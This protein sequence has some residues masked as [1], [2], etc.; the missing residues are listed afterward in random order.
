MPAPKYS[1]TSLLEVFHQFADD[2]GINTVSRSKVA[3]AL[4]QL[5]S[6]NNNVENWQKNTLDAYLRQ[7][8]VPA[9]PKH[10]LALFFEQIPKLL[11]RLQLQEFVL[12]LKESN[13]SISTI[14][15]YRSDIGQFLDFAQDSDLATLL[16]KPKINSFVRYQKQKGLKQSSITR[17]LKSIAQFG[18]WARE[19]GIDETQRDWLHNLSIETVAAP[20][21]VVP[22]ARNNSSKIHSNTKETVTA[23][24]A[25]SMAEWSDKI[26]RQ[27]AWKTRNQILPYLNLALIIL[28]FLGVTIF[29]YQQLTSESTP[30]L[31]YPTAV[32]R[33]TRV[34]SFQ[35]RLTDTAQNPITSST[36]MRF[37]LYD[38]VTGG[39]QL[40][41][42]GTCS[43]SPDQDGIFATGLGD[44]CGSEISADVFSENDSIWLEVEVASETLTPRQPIRT[45]PYAL[46]SETVQGFPINATESATANTILV[47][48]E[49][50]EVV[51]GENSPTI[52]STSGTFTLEGEAV[53]IQT[54][55]GSNGDIT[56]SPDGTGGVIITSTTTFQDSITVQGDGILTGYLAAPGATLSATYAG[57]TALVVQG[58][59]SGTATIQEWQQ[60]DGTVLNVIDENGYLGI[61]DTDPDALVNIQGTTEQLRLDYDDSNYVSFTVA[62]DGGL[63]IAGTGT[64]ADISLNP[65]GDLLFTDLDC[66]S[67][68]NGGALTV[69]AGGVVSCS[70]D[71]SGAGSGTSYWR[72]TSGA[73]S[74][75]ND[76][77][78]LL[79][80]GVSTASAKFAFINANSGTPTASISGNLA[81]AAP[82][83]ADPAITFDALNG[84]SLNF[85]T[86]VGG[87]AGSTTRVIIDNDGNVIPGAD[88]TYNLGSDTARWANLYVGTGGASFG[89]SGDAGTIDFNTTTDAFDL[90]FGG[91]QLSI[92]DVSNRP[93]FSSS[94]ATAIDFL[95]DVRISADNLDL[96]IGGS[97]DLQLTHNG[98]DSL[99]TSYTNDL[100]L[101]ADDDST[102]SQIQFGLEDGST[103]LG[104]FITGTNNQ[105]DFSV[106]SNTL[107]VDASSDSVGI[108]DSS[109]AS[110]FTVGNGDLFQ[111][112]NTGSII[113]I[114]GVAHSIA[115]VG[116]DLELN[117]NGGQI[118]FTD[119]DV[120]NIGGVTNQGY[121]A[122]SDAGT[123]TYASSDNDL[124]VE[125]I[126]EVDGTL[127]VGD[128]Q[129]SANALWQNDANV[130]HAANQYAGV[131]DLVVGG[132]STASA[133]IHL[134]ATNG[135][136]SA[137]RFQDLANSAYYLDPAA[138]GYSLLTAGS[139]G[140]G[141]TTP[142]AFLNIQGTTE[143]L[144]LDYDDSNYLS[145]TVASDGGT[146]F[147]GTGT[148]ADIIFDP[149][150]DL[151]FADL[152]CTGNTNGGS[153]TVDASGIVSCSDDDSGSS[154]TNY[155]RLTDGALS[156][157]NDTYDLLIG[158]ESTTSAAF[159]FMNV[160]S[161]TP[162]ASISGN[163]ALAAPTGSNPTTSLDILNGG[164]FNLRTSV[165][166][167]AGLTSRL[168]IDNDGNVGIGTETPS[169]Q[170]DIA[171][172][173]STIS[174]SS[175]DITLNAASDQI[176][177]S[178]D[179][180]GNLLNI[181]ASGQ[182]KPGSYGAN[183]TA[184]GNGAIIYRSDQTQLYYYDGTT[185]QSIASDA[186]VLFEN[187]A[188]VIHPKDELAEIADFVIGGTSTSSANIH[189][190]ATN[191]Y[192][193]GQRFQ[194]RAN[195]AYYLD[196][197][198]TDTSLTL[199]GKTGLGVAAP[200]FQ[201]E[202]EAANAG[203]T[204]AV[205]NQL[206]DQSIFV[207][208]SSGTNVFEL[209]NN[210]DV[211]IGNPTIDDVNIELHG[212]L[213]QPDETKLETA[214]TDIRQTFLYDT[215]QDRDGGAWRKSIISK[216]LSWYTESKDDAGLIAG[217]DLASDDRCGTSYFPAK[218]NL[219]LTNNALYVMDVTSNKLWMKFDQ[220]TS[221]AL[222]TT[223][224]NEPQS[225]YAKNGRLFVGT[226]GSSSETGLY[227]INFRTDE[228]RYYDTTGRTT[229]DENISGRNNGSHAFSGTEDAYKLAN[230]NINDIDGGYADGKQYL[231]VA[232]DAGVN[233]VDLDY[234]LTYDYKE[235]ASNANGDTISDDG[236]ASADAVNAFDGI[237]TTYVRSDAADDTLVVTYQFG[238]AK[239]I[240]R[241]GLVND[242]LGTFNEFPATWTF[243]GS[244]NGSTWTTLDTQTDYLF[245]DT[246]LTSNYQYFPINNDTAYTYYR[247]NVTDAQN[248]SADNITIGEI[249]LQERH[250]REAVRLFSDDVI[251][252]FNPAASAGNSAT[253]YSH[254]RIND[255]RRTNANG[256]FLTTSGV[257]YPEL[258]LTLREPDIFAKYMVTP[259]SNNTY[260]PTDWDLKASNDGVN[261]TT[262]DSE[263][264]VV[265]STYQPQTFDIASYSTAYK[266]YRLD[267]TGNNGSTLNTEVADFMMGT[268]T[269]TASTSFNDTTFDETN[270]IFQE[271]HG[272][273]YYWIASGDVDEW[274]QYDYG[275]GGERTMQA[276]VVRGYQTSQPTRA[277]TDWRV[278]GSNNGSTWTT[279][280]TQTS[281][282]WS[283]DNELKTYAFSNSTAYRY[284]RIYV[285]AVNGGTLSSFKQFYMLGSE[286]RLVASSDESDAAD[287]VSR[288]KDYGDFGR[289]TSYAGD[290]SGWIVKAFAPD[291][292]ATVSGIVLNGSASLNESIKDFT[293]QGSNDFSTWTDLG[294]IDR[295]VVED[296]THTRS[297]MFPND[298]A[299]QFYRLNIEAT[300]NS[301]I[302]SLDELDLLGSKYNNVRFTGDGFVATNV[303]TGQLDVFNKIFDNE[304]TRTEDGAEPNRHKALE[305]DGGGGLNT[306]KDV[307]LTTSD[308]DFEVDT[309]RRM[310]PLLGGGVEA[311]RRA[312]EVDG[313]EVF[314]GHANG[315]DQIRIN[316]NLKLEGTDLATDDDGEGRAQMQARYS[317]S[318]TIANKYGFEHYW[319][320]EQNDDVSKVYNFGIANSHSEVFGSGDYDNIPTSTASGK[321]GR[322]LEFDEATNQAVMFA[323]EAVQGWGNTS[324]TDEFS[325]G[326]WVRPDSDDVDTL[327]YD[328]LGD[329][330]LSTN[331]YG[332]M[333]RLDGN[334]QRIWL[335]GG[336]GGSGS[337]TVNQYSE[338]AVAE[339]DK[340]THFVIS[341]VNDNQGYVFNYYKN[342]ELVDTQAAGNLIDGGDFYLGAGGASSTTTT[343]DG[344]LDE[345]FI[346]YNALTDDEI[347]SIYN[348]G[349]TYDVNDSASMEG[350]NAITIDNASV[351][352]STTIGDSQLQMGVNE[353]AGRV[354]EITG[355]TGSGQSRLIVKNSATTVT[356]SPAW[357]TTPDSTSDFVITP[358]AVPGSVDEVKAARVDQKD[359]FLG[360]NDGSDGGGVVR[361]NRS[362]YDVTDYYHSGA[363]KTDDDSTAWDTTSGYD[364]I[365][366]IETTQDNL[367]IAS[368]TSYWRE[369][370]GDS[371]TE[372]IDKL[373]QA[374]SASIT[375][376]YT[377]DA[378]G[379]STRD[380]TRQVLRKGWSFLDTDDAS[381]DVYYG[382]SY[383][384]IP[385]VYISPAGKT[386]LSEIY[387]EP[388]SLQ[389]CQAAGAS[390]NEIT[391]GDIQRNQF[392]VQEETG[393]NSCFT[394][395]SIGD[396][397]GSMP[398]GSFAGGADLAEWY[399]TDDTTL[400]A[401]EIVAIDKSGDI[402]VV[403]S[404]TPQDSSA[405][406][407]IA[408]QPSIVMGPESGLTPGYT[409]VSN[410]DAEAAT[411]V[412]VALAG[413]VPVRVSLENGVIEP[414]DYLTT[415]SVPGVAV[416]AISAGPTIGKAM[417]QFDGSSTIVAVADADSEVDTAGLEA[418]V[419]NSIATDSATVNG[420]V[421]ILD[422]DQ[423]DLANGYGYV[424]AFVNTSYF[425]P[426]YAN[427]SGVDGESGDG[428]FAINS[429]GSLVGLGTYSF[430]LVDNSKYLNE[431]LA[432]AEAALSASDSASTSASLSRENIMTAALARLKTLGSLSLK[433]L[434]TAQLRVMD[435]IFSRKSQSDIAETDLLRPFV[436]N[437]LNFQ[438]GD[439]S[440]AGTLNIKNGNDEIVAQI[441]DRGNTTLLGQLLVNNDASIAGTLTANQLN[442]KSARLEELEGRLAQLESIKAQ[443]AEIVNATVSGTLF[444]DNIDG[445]QD[446]VEA[447]LEQPSLLSKLLGQE[448][449]ATSSATAIAAADIV[450]NAGYDTPSASSSAGLRASSFDRSLSELALPVDSISLAADA[451]FINDYFRTNGNAF[452][453]G[454]LGV[455]QHLFVENTVRVGRSTILSDGSLSFDVAET[456]TFAIQPSGQGNLSLMAGLLTLDQSG[457]AVI[458]GDLTVTGNLKVENTLLTDL[459]RPTDF[460]NPL[461]VQLATRSGE[462]A[463]AT[464]EVQESRFEIVN[465]LGAPVATISAQGRASFESG[466]GLGV[467]NL[468]DTTTATDSATISTTK[469]AGTAT[470][471]AGTNQLVIESAQVTE[472]TLVYITPLGPTGNQVMYVKAKSIDNPDTTENEASFTVGFENT[473]A[474]DINFNWWIV[475]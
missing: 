282:S 367:L 338:T 400:Q 253:T 302:T 285:D 81:I 345:V 414:G 52:T 296:A 340:W 319:P 418:A 160:N 447:A 422:N 289:W 246:G 370:V 424:M 286:D 428:S 337:P 159:A 223:T 186:N 105:G 11:T 473:V 281:V 410:P 374:F 315:L 58:G 275:S 18:L 128:T 419:N 192:V 115:D 325:V 323:D 403:R 332:L 363:A 277:V 457:Q 172:A 171:G 119:G 63:T 391:T 376:S 129:V 27:I 288:L 59:P 220:G 216:S 20:D 66:S 35:G 385:L 185:W 350:A 145:F 348:E 388:V 25:S 421:Q 138:T 365:I 114:D 22:S 80:G 142:D 329:Y 408:T 57:G 301:T 321:I 268:P 392:T 176:A 278:Q 133:S 406:G 161:G 231:F 255:W 46:N 183:P 461:Q 194:D 136:I 420:N 155:W 36:N 130:Y 415:G 83:G 249:Y 43:I 354:V 262:L 409:D 341:K 103:V 267:I 450:A 188:N 439:A 258:T 68:A 205:F 412:E 196:P 339:N 317:T 1:L 264:S 13:C 179:S 451:V 169:A 85:R 269:I 396:Y 387:D 87:D 361:I 157:I 399:G 266:H 312:L 232:T 273:G 251:R 436:G 233:M 40:W 26:K 210:G 324:Y 309:Q 250:Q 245:E 109:P 474:N 293:F 44:D 435:T 336:N 359:L 28:F 214:F 38:A 469:T 137:N 102:S 440:N 31:A 79:I 120:F 401:G 152:D 98:T 466:L 463:G 117:S 72:L 51:L 41:D 431:A 156:P 140:I 3:T 452:I 384:E 88:D 425:D 395:M 241:Y 69:S 147:A 368:R 228:I 274:I 416:K 126:L 86:S 226:A 243:Q 141:D 358:Y 342:G 313:N 224:N 446:K 195:S 187:T 24:V 432:E 437:D 42:S 5:F 164:S 355:G 207:A 444:A 383:D 151:I 244:N 177:F 54:V 369:K 261:W 202:V 240:R 438:I 373:Q 343:L 198:A 74:P 101:A 178:G 75:V 372:A 84:G 242:D 404:S 65:G 248:A 181:D 371:L 107:Y 33:P 73:F 287:D 135:Y 397:S 227:E 259:S 37:Y 139:V 254:R 377:T 448:T 97:Q 237:P 150:G 280:D 9:E 204:L 375:S 200:D 445:F 190:N 19:A 123:A 219:I 334:G 434:N 326:F 270:V 465:E 197:A 78:D 53:T 146:T 17:K 380:Y 460:T 284:Y 459:I 32:V 23:T 433:E 235:V 212:D 303:T 229:S 193:S 402:K 99:I 238:S 378:N 417:E 394:W 322:A 393:G 300:Y 201:L 272:I 390:T 413:R 127:Y 222:G 208:S 45:V 131:A 389:Q 110:L 144:R 8:T 30:T 297:Y 91:A 247:V 2:S 298:T 55:P 349:R 366:D 89:T 49:Y 104:Y 215:T 217:C 163:L 225:V 407:I 148:D 441:D 153:L 379:S 299:Y 112:D 173:S 279:L 92:D 21:A 82:T 265:F 347:R 331:I 456:D 234:Q 154:G 453:A 149:G 162:T 209:K 467:E 306:E 260:E 305:W 93:T 462:V 182:V 398:D 427:T 100:F 143:Q 50:G 4:S 381:R 132:T 430:D 291:Q 353:Y 475:N 344:R 206:A 60:S 111:V 221:N 96:Q 124:Y 449:E 199:V 304:N 166:G 61:G 29:G 442:G 70:D 62:S 122:I 39:T 386:G 257:I 362:S 295:S 106:D 14:K 271:T 180:L 90:T 174:N 16:T 113:A 118:N 158:G 310:N 71:D 239:T 168:F 356:V 230:D 429:D 352:S 175:G 213:F 276:Y 458:N 218:V 10:Q 423:Q 47:M 308:T 108:G 203:K 290:S 12:A 311:E 184:I 346:K 236:D 357:S 468:T 77:A 191:G 405:I 189:L 15:N 292:A 382:I 318:R 472:D 170:L 67:N 56:L 256:E 95:E 328:I 294:T 134:N 64:D 6:I 283:H 263:S 411:A 167:D 327:Y 335:Y 94:T 252:N 116:G 320:L 364:D 426:N 351:T 330:L 316:P 470:I 48:N 455:N 443:T 121:N 360:L 307:A 7:T 34:L 333:I 314:Y 471:K 165:G 125:D 211:E 454:S 76:T 464:D